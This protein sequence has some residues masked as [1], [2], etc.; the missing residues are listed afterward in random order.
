LLSLCRLE[1]V[2]RFGMV[3]QEVAAK[4]NKKWVKMAF[5]FMDSTDEYNLQNKHH[6]RWFYVS[7]DES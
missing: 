1:L 2:I 4:I 3:E 5:H 6:T 7:S